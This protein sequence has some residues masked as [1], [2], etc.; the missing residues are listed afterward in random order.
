MVAADFCAHA[1]AV[2]VCRDP[3]VVSVVHGDVS[4][5]LEDLD[6]PVLHVFDDGAFS[7]DDSFVLDLAVH[8][9]GVVQVEHVGGVLFL[10]LLLVLNYLHDIPVWEEFDCQPVLQ[11]DCEGS[12]DLL[13][14]LAELALLKLEFFLLFFLFSFEFD[15]ELHFVVKCRPK[16]GEIA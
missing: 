11:G 2:V 1:V 10:L 5:G 4:V 9:G 3:H 15:G 12:L 7:G 14:G 13:C 8:F 16:V 6:R